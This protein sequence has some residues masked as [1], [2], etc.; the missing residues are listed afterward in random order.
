MD[1]DQLKTFLEVVKT[2]H[3]G[4][5]AENLFITQSAVSA[6]IRQM[7]E[8]MGVKL[9]T[10]Q[11]NNIQLTPN[12]EQLV[13]YAENI[14]NTWN[15]AK[16]DIAVKSENKVPLSIGAVSSLW[17]IYLNRWLIKTSEFK[18][19][20]ALNCQSLGAEII[21]QKINN[22]TLDI[23]FTYNPPVDDTIKIIKKIPIKF[24]M[25]SSQKNQ[26]AADAINTNYIY[27]DWGTSF[28]AAH[29]EHFK[30]APTPAMRMDFGRIARN[31]IIK[32]G[33]AAYLPE[34]MIKRDLEKESLFLI[35]DA[36]LIKRY[37]YAIQNSNNERDK[38]I[39]KLFKS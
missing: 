19:E 17:D 1:D 25:V 36:P 30:D 4:K 31:Y 26:L 34:S 27:I 5:A 6:R 2:R 10:R 18:T 32:Q 37:A 39:Q 12:G 8:D 7:E 9:F 11:R 33:G 24:V 20:L 14:L 16:V 15:R 3:F 23:G 28:S 22:N 21:S 38:I 35:K 13:K 29:S